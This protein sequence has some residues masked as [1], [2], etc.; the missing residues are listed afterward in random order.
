MRSATPYA[1]QP[2]QWRGGDESSEEDWC[3]DRCRRLQE[4]HGNSDGRHNNYGSRKGHCSWPW[5]RPARI[6][7]GHFPVSLSCMM[8]SF[9]DFRYLAGCPAPIFQN[10]KLDVLG[11]RSVSI[12]GKL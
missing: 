10:R 4:E 1:L 8:G 11:G 7:D 6:D 9:T 12:E 5:H 2:A 3:N